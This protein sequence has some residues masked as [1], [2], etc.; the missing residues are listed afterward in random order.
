MNMP[1]IK[2]P[3][4]ADPIK[5]ISELKNTDPDKI[6]RATRRLAPELIPSTY[7]PANGF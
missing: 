3:R 2:A 4:S 1:K 6:P 5:P 7:G